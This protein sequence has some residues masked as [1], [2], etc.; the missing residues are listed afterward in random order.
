MDRVPEQYFK[1]LVGTDH[2]WEVRIRTAGNSYRFLGVFD[3]PV[4]MVLTSGFSKKQRKTPRREI[5]QAE[6]RRLNYLPR[7]KS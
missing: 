2:L 6:S 3:G 1:E 4:L 7:R 5:D